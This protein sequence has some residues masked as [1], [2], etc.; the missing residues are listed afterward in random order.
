MFS[1]RRLFA[2]I[3]GICLLAWTAAPGLG[4]E[5]VKTPAMPDD[6]ETEDDRGPREKRVDFR[7]SLTTEQDD[8]ILHLRADTVD[9][10]EAGG[11]PPDRFLINSVD[12]VIF[13][14]SFDLAFTLTPQTRKRSRVRLSTDVYQYMDNSIKDY[15]QYRLTFEQDVSDARVD[16]REL[17]L[18]KEEL[19]STRFRTRRSFRLANR[20]RLRLSYLHGPDRYQSQLTDDDGGGRKSA[21][22][23]TDA[24]DARYYQRLNRGEANRWR[25]L[26]RAGRDEID[27][28]AEFDE[29][30]SER[31][32]Y[33]V[34]LDYFSLWSDSY[35]QLGLTYGFAERRSNTALIGRLG[36]A[37]TI[38]DDLSYDADVI[39]LSAGRFW[40]RE[41]GLR[42]LYKGNSFQVAAR[43]GQK[44]YI[45]RNQND[46]THFG[47]NDDYVAVRAAYT[48]ALSNS[49][50]ARLLVEYAEQQT[51]LDPLDGFDRL[52]PSD[53]D[54]LVIGFQLSYY[55]GWKSRTQRQAPARAPVVVTETV[56]PPLET[57]PP[58]PA[59]ALGYE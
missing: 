32:H 51:N 34:G 9:E 55:A 21:F 49:A 19:S 30:D 11:F 15:E 17:E 43:Y 37:G 25:L 45:T 40:Y 57:E 35:W 8:N 39:T 41:K 6:L 10:F 58:S 54:N 2:A 5:A 12:D 48:H 27:Y 13:N 23:V 36:P 26:L 56:P 7:V 22:F 24:W 46:L 18:A 52:E 44:D 29:R 31:D 42:A 53:F 4:D 28:N 16:L 50:T 33:A 1:T 3:F 38:E 59:E 47:R 20:S 14:P